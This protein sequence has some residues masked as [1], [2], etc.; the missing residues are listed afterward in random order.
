MENR[1]VLRDK[2]EELLNILIE[3]EEIDDNLI[4]DLIF[5]EEAFNI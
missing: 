2:L 4:R 5:R 3:G 1:D